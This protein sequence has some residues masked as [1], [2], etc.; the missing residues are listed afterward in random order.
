MRKFQ[1]AQNPTKIFQKIPRGT[2][3]DAQ[4]P[5]RNFQKSYEELS[6]CT[7]S[8]KNLPRYNNSHEELP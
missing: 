2:S 5:I 1:N 3:K 8:H 7:I 4:N 6:N